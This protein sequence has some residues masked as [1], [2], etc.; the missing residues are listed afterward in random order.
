MIEWSR[1]LCYGVVQQVTSL[2]SAFSLL[3]FLSIIS[4]VVIDELSG[5]EW[6]RASG[7]ELI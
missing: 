4:I 6:S 3:S 2:A 7:F 5:V 1:R